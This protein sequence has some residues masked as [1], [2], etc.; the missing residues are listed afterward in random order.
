MPERRKRPAPPTS[1][2]C[3]EL[4]ALAET[5]SRARARVTDLAEPF[6]GTEREDVAFALHEAERLLVQSE[7]SLHRALK[8]AD[9]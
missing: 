1:T 2:T 4:S 8:I 5:V 7:R 3:A 9:H 6:M